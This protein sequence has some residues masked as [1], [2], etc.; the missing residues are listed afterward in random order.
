ME[1][2]TRK[3]TPSRDTTPVEEAAFA[4][5]PETAKGSSAAIMTA[6]SAR[7]RKR[8]IILVIKVHLGK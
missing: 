3:F 7:H 2:P 5:V 1:G 6:A 8:R 4:V